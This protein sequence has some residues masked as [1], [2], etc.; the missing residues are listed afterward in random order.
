[1]QQKY[2]LV[3]MNS[4]MAHVCNFTFLLWLVRKKSISKQVYI[5]HQIKLTKFVSLIKLVN[6]IS[7]YFNAFTAFI[8]RLHFFNDSYILTR[9][10][11]RI[12][13]LTRPLLKWRI[14]M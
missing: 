2:M 7:N 5:L 13:L 8:L 10:R 6:H 1:M 4:V 3:Y 12:T 9:S 14:N 11:M